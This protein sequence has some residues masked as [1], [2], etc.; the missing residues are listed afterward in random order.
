MLNTIERPK[1]RAIV[2]TICGEP[3]L[4]KTS[5]AAS[6]PKPIFIRAEDGLQ[7]IALADRPDAFP[8]LKSGLDIFAQLAALLKE[9]H[10]YATVVI[11]SITELDQLFERHV[12]DSDPKAPASINQAAGGYGAGYAAIAALH[13]R[14]KRGCD[15][16]NERGMNVVFIAHTTTTTVRPPDMDDFSRYTLR[17]HDKS[18]A[19]YL[20]KVDLVGFLRLSQS[21][22]KGN[23]DR[24]MVKSTGSRELITYATP[25]NVS[26]N[27]YGITQSLL[28]EQGENPLAGLVPLSKG[29]SKL[30]RAKKAEQNTTETYKEELTND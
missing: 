14:V 29:I 6:F 21:V 16:L 7:S 22:I 24:S 2:A 19:S 28:V 23:N 18:S 20:D 10:T 17:M 26:K 9:E 27:R 8:V 11:D 25:A 15:M 5:L 30:A 1:D 12:I 4:G 13:Q 3:G